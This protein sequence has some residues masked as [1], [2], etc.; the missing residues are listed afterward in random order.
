MTTAT[1]HI[2]VPKNLLLKANGGQGQVYA[3]GW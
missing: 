3:N 2:D 1:I